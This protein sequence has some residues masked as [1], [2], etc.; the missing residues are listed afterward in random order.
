[1]RLDVLIENRADDDANLPG[2]HGLSVLVRAHGR[3]LLFDTGASGNAVTNADAL[4]LG[5]ALAQ[6]D[7]IVVSHGH[8]DHAGGLRAVLER[9]RRPIPVHVRPGFFASRLSLRDGTP[10]DIGVPFPR[11]ELEA[12]GA[13]FI[14]ETEPRQILPGFWLSG[15]IPLREEATPNATNLFLGSSPA[16]AT[17]DPFTDEHAL[18]VETAQGLV[19]LVGCG[20]RGIVNS[21]V[22]AQAA[23]GGAPVRMVLGGAH[24]HSADGGRIAKAIERTRALTSEAALGHCTGEAVEGRFAT[25]IGASFQ[26]LRTG[27]HWET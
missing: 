10:R 14:D 9:R 21:I 4:G 15:E 23:A 17:A 19:V 2:E 26:R 22:T 6:L 20:H 3:H 1:M 12:Q 18:A 5:K 16:E 27:W 8:Y 13:S 24:L 11:Q 7:A 25:A